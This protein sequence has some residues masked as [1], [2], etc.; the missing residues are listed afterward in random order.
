MSGGGMRTSVASMRDGGKIVSS[1]LIAQLHE[2]MPACDEK[3]ARAFAEHVLAEKPSPMF[4]S[5][6]R[7]IM[8]RGTSP[9]QLLVALLR[10]EW[11]ELRRLLTESG[12]M[13][14]SRQVKRFSDCVDRYKALQTAVVRE[15]ERRWEHALKAERRARCL[16][17]ARME[18]LRSRRIDLHNYFKEIPVRAGLEVKEVTENGVIVVFSP[19]AVLVFVASNDL[20]TAYVSREGDMRLKLCGRR[21][22]GDLLY[23]SVDAVEA[24]LL[25]RRKYVRVRMAEPVPVDILGKRKYPANIR[26]ASIY[27]LG[28]MFSGGVGVAVKKGGLKTGEKVECVW[29]SDG[30]MLSAPGVVRWCGKVDG[31]WRAGLEIRPNYV[32]RSHLQQLLMKYQREVIGRLRSLEVPAWMRL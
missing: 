12:R 13:E 7:E 24:D 22:D 19:E 28:V 21:R 3:T 29:R 14:P 20:R 30:K 26:D 6:A 31:E 5:L 18:W 2:D 23:L 17:E 11:H 15:A 32:T 10:Y 27:G 16:A 25:A 4:G 1:G 9:G 8:E